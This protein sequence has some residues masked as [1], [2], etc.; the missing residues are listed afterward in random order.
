VLFADVANPA[1]NR[2]Y[3]RLGF[4]PVA[5]NVQYAFTST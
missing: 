3:R 1:S 2:I 4:V 5:E